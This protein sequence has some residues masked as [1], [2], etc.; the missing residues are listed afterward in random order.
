MTAITTALRNRFFLTGILCG[1]LFGVVT[2]TLLA[3]GVGNNRVD[4]VR[5]SL[6]RLVRRERSP[7]Y[8]K[9]FV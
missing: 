3:F 4:T 2:G 1:A 6:T 5:V 7:D 8:S 9:I